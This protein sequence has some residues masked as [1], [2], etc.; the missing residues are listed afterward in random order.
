MGFK[1]KTDNDSQYRILVSNSR[2]GVVNAT[3][4][5]AIMLSRWVKSILTNIQWKPRYVLSILFYF[6]T[7][8]NRSSYLTL[9]SPNQKAS[10]V[11]HFQPSSVI[12]FHWNSPLTISW[13]FGNSEDSNLVCGES[14]HRHAEKFAS[15]V[16]GNAKMA[17]IKGSS[18]RESKYS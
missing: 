14:M 2:L 15:A 7:I 3:M 12:R 16:R 1:T 11:Q 9:T 17:A 10:K 13:I 5:N 18:A 6:I 4:Q 8:V